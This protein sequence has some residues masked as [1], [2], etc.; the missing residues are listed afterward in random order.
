MALIQGPQSAYYIITK[1]EDSNGQPR[2][3][4]GT[5]LVVQAPWDTWN[6]PIATPP[7][8]K[9]PLGCSA[10]RMS[11][12]FRSAD[13]FSADN[14]G[15]FAIGIRGNLDNGLLGRGIILGN[16]SA[17]HPDEAT[18]QV[19]TL[20]VESFWREGVR[21]YGPQTE[22]PALRNNEDYRVTIECSRVDATAIGYMIERKVG[23]RWTERVR[24]RVIDTFGKGKVPAD[25]GGFFIAEV[26]SQHR[27]QMHIRNLN[28]LF[29]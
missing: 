14:I 18:R 10:M 7:G 23:G 11:F 4:G 6:G 17:L 26:F 21:V 16:V 1:P 12:E 15:H 2:P 9:L 29:Y 20:A 25:D 5:D 27:W 28:V 8:T 13:Y 24:K 3:P 19:N 22:G